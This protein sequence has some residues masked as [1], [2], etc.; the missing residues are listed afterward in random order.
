MA[1]RL[2]ASAHYLLTNL[3]PSL[4][5]ENVFTLNTFCLFTLNN[6]RGVPFEQCESTWSADLI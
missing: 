1:P 3:R 5:P 2:G 4:T 6:V